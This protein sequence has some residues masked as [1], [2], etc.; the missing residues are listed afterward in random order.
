MK[1][2]LVVSAVLALLFAL[3]LAADDGARDNGARNEAVAA[4][5]AWHGAHGAEI[6]AELAAL[7][8]IPNV[9]SDGPNI[10]ANAEAIATAFRRRGAE[11]EL[12]TLPDAPEVPPVVFGT[13]PAEEGADTAPTLVLYVHYDGQPVDPARW[14]FGPWTPTLTTAAVDAGGTARPLPAPGEAI[15]PEWRLYARAASDDKAPLVAL[16]AALDALAA[17]GVPRRTHVKLFFEGEEEAGSPHLA[18]YVDR[19][20]ER[21]ARE[22]PDHGR[23]PVR[24]AARR[25]DAR[26]LVQHVVDE[27]RL[28]ADRRTVDLD[29]VTIGFDAATE[30]GDL[31]V[32]GDSS[33]CD[34]IL[35]RAPTPESDR[36]QHLLQAFTG[37]EFGIALG[38]LFPERPTVILGRHRT[39]TPSR[40]CR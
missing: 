1:R 37:V 38:E 34:E 20:A 28:D 15:D 13:L 18:R 22:E 26:W 17:A 3:P 4:A 7:L 19:Y 29:E 27:I 35:T 14:T 9:A 21:L 10:R 36:G 32:D 30:H 31:T 24:V 5:R 2:T 16:T 8:E 25:D 11:M 40:S 23:T 33:G 12:L 6:V 39:T